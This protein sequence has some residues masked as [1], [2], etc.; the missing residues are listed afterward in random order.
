MLFAYPQPELLAPSFKR[1]AGEQFKVKPTAWRVHNGQRVEV[2][3]SL[4]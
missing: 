1:I 4:V 2:F 3:A